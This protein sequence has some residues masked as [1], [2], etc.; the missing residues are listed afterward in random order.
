MLELN[1]TSSYTDN[2]QRRNNTYGWNGFWVQKL[3]FGTG[4]C[5]VVTTDDNCLLMH[6]N[7]HLYYFRNG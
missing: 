3:I 5:Q 1:L 7:I 4:L 2:Y 6:K